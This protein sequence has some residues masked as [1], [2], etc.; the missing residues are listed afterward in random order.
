MRSLNT[1][2][3]ILP[4]VN[5]NGNTYNGIVPNISLFLSNESKYTKQD[6]MSLVM[7]FIGNIMH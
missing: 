2:V 6:R 5:I 4:A 1:C 3:Y 7:M